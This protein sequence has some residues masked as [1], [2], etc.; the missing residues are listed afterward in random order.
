MVK[1][2]LISIVHQYQ[3]IKIKIVLTNK[4]INK[5]HQN[6]GLRLLLK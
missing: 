2:K 4:N 3:Q 6:E 5:K 1:N